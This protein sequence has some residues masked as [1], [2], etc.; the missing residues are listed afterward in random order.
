[1]SR[2]FPGP[3]VIAPVWLP[4]EPLNLRSCVGSLVSAATLRLPR[5]PTPTQ[6]LVDVPYGTELPRPLAQLEPWLTCAYATGYEP[7]ELKYVPAAPSSANGRATLSKVP[8]C[9]ELPEPVDQLSVC[10]A[11]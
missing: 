9:F 3:Q 4:F 10:A 7:A 2:R 8:F 6:K 1:M 11:W 5:M